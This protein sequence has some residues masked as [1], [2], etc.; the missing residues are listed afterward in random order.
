MVGLPPVLFESDPLS[1]YLLT[2][3]L[4]YVGPTVKIGNFHKGVDIICS[5]TIGG[6]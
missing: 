4:V 5:D 2:D 6:L 3:L 1:V